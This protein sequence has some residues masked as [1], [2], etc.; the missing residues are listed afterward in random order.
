MNGLIATY[1]AGNSLHINREYRVDVDHCW[2][3][4]FKSVSNQSPI[5]GHFILGDKNK[6][7]TINA[8]IIAKK[9]I[10]VHS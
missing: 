8:I 5:L 9:H 1:V 2:S 4:I 10:N 3:P 6:T 7:L